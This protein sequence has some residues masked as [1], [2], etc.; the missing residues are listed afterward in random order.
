MKDNKKNGN[1]FVIILFVLVVILVLL[2]PKL[3]NYIEKQKL[4]EIKDNTSSTSE[5]TEE[6]T[7]DLLEEVH[8][9]IMRNS[10]YSS[11][12]Y[13]SLNTFTISDMSNKDILYN[14]F[15]N[16]YSG[17]ITSSKYYSRCSNTP[18][19]FEQK[20]IELRIKNS[21]GKNIEYSLESFS[22]PEDSNSKYNGEWRY[23]SLNKIFIY[24]G[25][26]SSKKTD[27]T[28][29]DLEQLIKREFE[30]DDLVVYYYVGFAKVVGNSYTI[31]SDA[32][33]QNSITSGTFND[34]N[35]LNTMFEN[36]DNSLK[37]KYKYTFRKSL[38]SYD[39]YCLYKGEYINE[40]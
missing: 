4:P 21:L 25:V 30:Q 35:E 36:I 24:D 33:M 1:L 22:V 14:A 34:I 31:Y 10:I 9:P 32:L 15:S 8:F 12:T 23:D 5:E 19:Q 3:Y 40:L 39:A 11:D 38:C 20:Y 17:Y 6:I 28:Y 7:D 27:T 37:K 26:C 18:A 29:Y 16:M 13:Y 2:F